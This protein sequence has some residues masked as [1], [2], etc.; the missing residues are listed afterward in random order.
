MCWETMSLRFARLFLYHKS[1]VNVVGGEEGIVFCEIVPFAINQRRMWLE[2]RNE[3]VF[4]WPSVQGQCG[5]RI[6]MSNVL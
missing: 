6:G 3:Q 1:D 4:L 2:D 5:R